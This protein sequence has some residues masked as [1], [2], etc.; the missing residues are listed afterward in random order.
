M[1]RPRLAT[2]WLSGCSGCHMSLLNL[3]DQ[4]LKLLSQC[5]LV[6][7]PLM[8][9]KEYPAEVD[10]VVIEGAVASR[11]N[12]EQAESI[13]GRTRIVISMG[14]CAVNGNVSAL[15]NPLNLADTVRS[16]YGEG[17]LLESGITE[18]S[19][20]VMPL[21][22]VIRVDAFIPGCPPKPS[23]I[24]SELGRFLKSV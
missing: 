2:V 22:H 1:S 21:H 14:D 20:K 11:E 9:I 4:L 3:H 17:S 13:R 16:C 8:D 10:I 23:L 24:Y 15:R 7:S 12:R 5:D 19:A 6:Y 18:L